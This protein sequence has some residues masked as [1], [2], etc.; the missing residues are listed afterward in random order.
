MGVRVSVSVKTAQ[1]DSLP[2]SIVAVT[3]GYKYIIYV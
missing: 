1:K 2:S 3:A